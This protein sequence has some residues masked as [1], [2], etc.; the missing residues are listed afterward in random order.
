MTAATANRDTPRF[1]EDVLA[2]EM[3]P[4]P[5]AA[6]T[7]IFQGTLVALNLAGNLVPLSADPTLYCV[8]VA[9]READNTAGAAGDI[10]CKVERGV[11]GF[12]NS[13]T[14]SALSALHIGQVCYGVDDQTV[15]RLTAIGTL[16]QVGRVVG[17]EGTTV[18]VEVGNLDRSQGAHDFYIVTAADLSVTGQNRFV[19]L[20]A[21]G[22]VVLAATA[23]QHA[24]GALLN[25]PGTGAVAIVRRRGPVRMLA[26][27]AI[28]EN[29][30]IA[31][32]V[33]TGRYKTAVNT[34]CDSSGA[35]A[36]APLSGSSVMGL[37]LEE[38]TGAGDLALVDLH[39]MGAIPGTLA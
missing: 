39:P 5:V 4:M 37:T 32:A 24:F 25:A 36:T 16:P 14:T 9:Q 7:R 21:A 23:G 12:T 35:S 1:G 34:T 27:A 13:A 10:T 30:C 20:D 6:A 2:R 28:A 11:F 19:A 18:L 26:E 38:S 29:V 3:K 22:L 15:A 8:G 31:V 17:M 33:T